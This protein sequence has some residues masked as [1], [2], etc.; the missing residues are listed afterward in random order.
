MALR[1]IAQPVG[2]SRGMSQIGVEIHV[3]VAGKEFV[4]RDEMTI[5]LRY[6][7]NPV[8]IEGGLWQT[9]LGFCA[10]EYIDVG[11]FVG[12]GTRGGRRHSVGKFVDKRLLPGA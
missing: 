9:G 12:D 7:L 5:T 2:L 1:E 11:V 6:T 10:L 8:H 4:R 3:L